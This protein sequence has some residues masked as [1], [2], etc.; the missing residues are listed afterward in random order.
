MRVVTNLRGKDS[1]KI[2]NL[3]LRC[4]ANYP[5]RLPD[6]IELRIAGVDALIIEEN[7]AIISLSSAGDEMRPVFFERLN[8]IFIR[9]SLDV[10]PRLLED[11]MVLRE[12]AK[13]LGDEYLGYLYGRLLGRKARNFS[14]YLNASAAWVAFHPVDKA[15]AD[16]LYQITK[17]KAYEARAKSLFE[18]L[19]RNLWVG[20]NLEKAAKKLGRLNAGNE[21][22]MGK[23]GAVPDPQQRKRLRAPEAS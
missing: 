19:K 5:N 6:T 10:M 2:T 4:L 8:R 18:A 12:T 13:M 1:G 14:E 23:L 15:D 7:R 22:Q 11:V 9:R 16:M 17:N 21:I 20:S 3:F